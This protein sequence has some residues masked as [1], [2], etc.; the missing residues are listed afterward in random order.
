METYTEIRALQGPCIPPQMAAAARQLGQAAAGSFFLVSPSNTG[1]IVRCLSQAITK[2]L[3][4]VEQPGHRLA[5]IW[6]A[7]AACDSCTHYPAVPAPRQSCLCWR[8]NIL[9]QGHSLCGSCGGGCGLS[10]SSLTLQLSG[11][12]F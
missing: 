4:E 3:M 2:V 7:G 1:A 10:P 5:P 8:L 9:V 12:V 11:L 6:D